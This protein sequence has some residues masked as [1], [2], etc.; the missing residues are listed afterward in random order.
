MTAQEATDPLEELQRE[1]EVA[2][3]LL[4]KLVELGEGLRSKDP[5]SS[6]EISTAVDLL[7]QYLH[8]VHA[9]RIDQVLVP[10][11]RPVAMST[12]FEHLD[13]VKSAHETAHEKAA[14]LHRRLSEGTVQGDAERESLAEALIDLGSS[15]HDMMVY[16]ETY[17]LSCLVATL[18]EDAAGRVHGEFERSSAADL[19]DL[20]DHIRRFLARPAPAAEP[21]R[22]K[23]THP[24]CDHGGDAHAV[25]AEKGQ[26]GLEAPAGGWAAIP[27]APEARAGVVSTRVDFVCPTHRSEPAI[28]APACT[29]GGKGTS[30]S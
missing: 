9:R 16:E 5:P 1:H 22:V 20:E 11:A 8:Q 24:G 14:T 15:D 26:F 23:C 7:D 19:A 30:S 27:H 28:A 18:P 17:P 12:C 10:E 2:R 21:V 3:P 4:E 6:G 29:T 13:A 25:A